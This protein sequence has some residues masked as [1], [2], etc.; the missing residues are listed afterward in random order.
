MHCSTCERKIKRFGK[1]GE[2]KPN[3]VKILPS[4]KEKMCIKET[5]RVRRIMMTFDSFLH[6][7]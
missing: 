3:D 4:V 2:M 1:G 5:H 6:N 7:A